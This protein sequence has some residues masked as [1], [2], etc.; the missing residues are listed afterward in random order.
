V[1]GV[2]ELRTAH[3]DDAALYAGRCSF[4]GD[5][6]AS[7]VRE[8]HDPSGAVF[9]W[10]E[11]TIDFRL[12][13]P[14]DGAAFVSAAVGAP[15]VGSP[16]LKS[17]FDRLGP[18]EGTV[19][20]ATEYPGIRFRLELMFSV[21]TFHLGD[22][23]LPGALNA[24]H[25]VVPDPGRTSDDIAFILPKVTF[26]YEQGDDL[27]RPPTF[28]LAS[29]GSGGFD[30]PH[31][32]A[33]GEVVRMEPPLAIHES[34]RVGFGVGQVVLDLS[35]RS[36]PPEILRFFG[37]DEGWK[38]I[39]VR[40]ARVFWSDKDKGWAVN[41]AVED[42]LVSFAGQV[43]LEASLDVIG[44]E[45][46]M[47][48][49][50]HLY[51]GPLEVPYV[52][53]T[54]ATPLV[55][56]RGTILNTG[57]VHVHIAGGVPPYVVHVRLGSEELWN[58]TTRTAPISPGGAAAPHAPV[59]A[60]LHVSVTDSGTTTAPNPTRQ[61]YL[62][63]VDLTVRGAAVAGAPRDGAPADRPP[64]TAPRPGAVFEV[65]ASTPS[66]LPPGYDVTCTPSASGLT[67][68]VV[69]SGPPGATVTV[70][71]VARALDATGSFSL[72]VAESADI[73]I[74]VSW[75]DP[76]PT[77]PPRQSFRLRFARGGPRA[78]LGDIGFE[79][80]IPDYVADAESPPDIPFGQSIPDGGPA[81][82]TGAAGLK[83]WI[84]S[85]VNAGADAHITIDA[86]AGFVR[87][88]DAALD[89]KLS[90]RRLAVAQAIIREARPGATFDRA[91]AHGH[92]G[93]Q[94]S[95]S[96]GAAEHDVAIVEA[97]TGSAPGAV[98]TTVFDRVEAFDRWVTQP[99]IKDSFAVD[100]A[101][102][103]IGPPYLLQN[104]APVETVSKLKLETP[105][106][107]GTTAVPSSYWDAIVAL[108]RL[109]ADPDDV[110]ST[111][112]VVAADPR[113]QL[114][115]RLNLCYPADPGDLDHP[116][117][118]AAATPPRLPVVVIAHGN[119]AHWHPTATSATETQNHQ[120]TSTSRPTSR[121]T[122]SCRCRSTATSPTTSTAT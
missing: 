83:H 53:G 59:R 82:P 52:K 68:R 50:V 60:T 93:A 116:V 6:G 108:G 15:A 121:S 4:V 69:V 115:L 44:P 24:D 22:A 67:E 119:H 55:A 48:A 99:L 42:L 27:G 37:V 100:L 109:R 38:G 47:R 5:A 84:S 13:L 30:A 94:A 16:E 118:A 74:V 79:A 81:T 64:D 107:R 85:S 86:H 122:A 26:V 23:W 58:P 9:R 36:T 18:V 39:Y 25:R 14:R 17:L 90:E 11:V 19:V 98:A 7:P 112:A 32:L 73:P 111:D 113:F 120:A 45:A 57:V 71:G 105:L 72:D 97:A 20:V 91:L 21:L 101:G 76:S 31:D 8:H 66:T 61:V 117:G 92:T 106:F 114:R 65:V 56:G 35:E 80:V 103:L 51:E 89:Q 102:N 95:T 40:S 3:D 87:P 77:T 96:P 49:S 54:T 75:P 34:G 78:D 2:D 12:T 63:D 10:E 70:G 110:A 28:E 62:E 29:W 46:R 1:L 41:V 88:E 33:A 43:S 104:A